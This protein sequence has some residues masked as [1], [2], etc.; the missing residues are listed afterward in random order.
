MCFLRGG[1]KKKMAN[2]K[3]GAF[4]TT[5]DVG[6][7]RIPG[8]TVY[9]AASQ[10]YTITG[11]GN[12]IWGS[13]DEFHFAALKATGNFILSVQGELLGK[14]KNAHRK[15]G[16]MLRKNLT[17]VSAHADATVHGDGLTSLQYRPSKGAQTSEL[18][19]S[20]TA[21]DMVQLERSGRDIIMRAAK[22][23][24]PLVETGRVQIG[25]SGEVYAGL[26]VCSH[27]I[28]VAETA[29]F[30]NFRFDVPAAKGVDGWENPSPSRLEI[31]EVATG[32]RRVIYTSSKHFEAPNWSRDGRY[33]LFNQEGKI[34][35]FVLGQNRPRVLKTGKVKRN[36]NDHGISFDGKKL[37]LSSHTR[38]KGRKEGS[39]IYVVDI[40]GGE[41]VKVTDQAPSYWHGWSPDGKV[42]VYCAEREGNYD[43]YAIPAKGGTETRLTTDPGLDDGPEY[44]PDGRYIYF[45][46][47]RT[48]QMKIWRM[49]PDGTKQQ[50][51]SFGHSNDWFAHLSP[52]G[53]RMVYI[54][55][56]LSVP[57][58]S[59][60]HN[61][62]VM[63][64]EQMVSS[65]KVRVVAH[66]YGGQGSLNVPS[67]S[68]DGKYVAFVSYTYGDPAI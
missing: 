61:Q 14:G 58:A 50:Q 17:S 7:Q 67:W 68:P 62:R 35:K 39:Q 59:H 3:T 31:L 29:V 49:K 42:L 25:L 12:N 57:A 54:S 36:N 56:P 4:D 21:P 5:S 45:N 55:Y 64:R 8:K 66:L 16:L 48:G 37:A 20:L 22:L 26:F 2:K 51:V 15:W 65:G 44:S 13:E 19:A 6:T 47:N 52:D 43:I 28:D 11:G 32:H 46:S 33:L 18:R 1:G 27:R 63:I 34:M 40:K 9:D 38:Q 53:K 30:T 24:E 10:T 23:G 60:P 41:P